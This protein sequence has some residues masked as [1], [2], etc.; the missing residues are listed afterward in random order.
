M[1]AETELERL[2]VRLTGDS[3]DFTKSMEDS[4]KAAVAAAGKV[5]EAGKKVEG[6]SSRMKALGQAALGTLTALG[7][8]EWL[9]EAKNAY[10]EQAGA[11]RKLKAA[12]EVNGRTVNTLF[13]DYMDF[14]GGIQKVTVVADEMTLGLIKQAELLGVTGEAAKRAARNAIALGA[15]WDG[16]AD[17]Y[18]RMTALLEQGKLGRIGMLLG[19]GELEEGADKVAVA[20]E[21]LAKMFQFAT[22]EAKSLGGQTKQLENNYNNLLEKFGAIIAET[23]KPVKT[24][25]LDWGSKVTA[26]F[27]AMPKVVK[28]LI[29]AVAALALSFG[30]LVA[31]VGLAKVVKL[32]GAF[33]TVRTAVLAV[34]G[35]IPAIAMFI[36][37]WVAAAAAVVGLTKAVISLNAEASKLY[38]SLEDSLKAGKDLQNTQVKRFTEGTTQTMGKAGGMVFGE[39]KQ[40]FLTKELAKAQK[41]MTGY[42]NN[43]NS[44]KKLISDNYIALDAMLGNK[45]LEQL[46]ANL[47]EH[48][49]MLGLAKD[50]TE[51]INA[52]LMKLKAPAMDPQL[53]ETIA[54]LTRSLEIAA[55]TIGKTAEEAELLKLKLKGAT[56]EMLANAEGLMRMNDQLKKQAELD[57]NIKSTIAALED[58]AAAFG[59]TA[60]EIKLMKLQQQGANEEQL[61]T[62]KR[63]MDNNAACE[64]YTK[65]V[66]RAKQ[67]MEE[68]ATPQEQAAVKLAELK[69]LFDAGVLPIEAYERAVKSVQEALA[70]AGGEA[71]SAADSFDAAASGSAEAI[72]RIAKF[73]ESIKVNNKRGN[74][75]GMPG[76]DANMPVP[77]RHGEANAPAGNREELGLFKQIV[78]ILGKIA[79]KPM[80]ELEVADA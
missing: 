21:K 66:E 24:A 60:D 39:Q 14:A 11:E 64:K 33:V 63:L 51:Q 18:I 47:S 7:A 37:P 48:E 27:E 35:T 50:R 26:M 72:S 75:P 79:D 76:Q 54:E 62:V 74:V 29:V 3:K 59:N 69:E 43:V 31:I 57:A 56:D 65:Q 55:M 68:F 34:L 25:V 78:Q 36:L 71:K 12:L 67:I 38:K 2:V 4:S 42:Q 40:E 1:A 5:E 49:Q 46:N 73:R 61:K 22:K 19:M 44:T 20:Q 23:S 10:G 28:Q 30:S 58:E 15:V 70:K 41:L 32:A 77:G 80:V 53:I 17:G 13:K 9:K 16:Q 8:G 6:I 52:E 45:M